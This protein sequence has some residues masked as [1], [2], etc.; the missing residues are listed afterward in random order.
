MTK[1]KY[2]SPLSQASED[3]GVSV[4]FARRILAHKHQRKHLTKGKMIEVAIDVPQEI[5]DV[6]KNIATNLKVS[7]SVVASAI[8]EQGIEISNRTQWNTEK[9]LEGVTP[10]K[11]AAV[12][13]SIKNVKL[14]KPPG[15]VLIKENSDKPVTKSNDDH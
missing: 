9:L 14:P 5:I 11:L 2:K 6:L 8:L 7:V 10:E 15:N 13:P 1:T 3:A 12:T 4:D